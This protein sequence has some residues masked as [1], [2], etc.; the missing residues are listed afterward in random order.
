VVGIN[1]RLA[2]S[3]FEP[4]ACMKAPRVPRSSATQAMT[5]EY[6]KCCGA[7]RISHRP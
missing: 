6:V 3:S 4:Y 1:K 5:F 7:P 2:S